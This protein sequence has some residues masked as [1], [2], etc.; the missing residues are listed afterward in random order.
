MRADAWVSLPPGA[1]PQRSLRIE[2]IPKRGQDLTL[3]V[4][5][6]EDCV[7][8]VDEQRPARVSPGT[9]ETLGQDLLVELPVERALLDARRLE[10]TRGDQTLRLQRQ[11]TAW[12]DDTGGPV[13]EAQAWLTERSTVAT[14]ALRSGPVPSPQAWSLRVLP[15]QG[16]AYTFEG[17]PGW[18]RIAGQQ[19]WYAIEPEPIDE[20]VDDASPSE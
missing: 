5:L 13:P 20:D 6:F 17:G 2:R 15:Q 18:L 12:V 9:C 7:V 11:G 16:T 4:A 10:L 19:W 3:E 1:Q 8:V 14:P